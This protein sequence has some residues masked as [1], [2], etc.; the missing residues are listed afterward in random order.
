MRRLALAALS[1]AIACTTSPR[2]PQTNPAAGAQ[3]RADV[4]VERARALRAGG[5]VAG[6]RSR[7]EA[8]LEAEPSS[9]PARIELADLLLA[10]ASEVDRAALL[11]AG[12]SGADGDAR[13]Q[14]LQARLAE[15]RGDDAGAAAAYE[16]ALQLEDD[17]DARLRRAIALDRVG[18]RD[19]ATAEL[20][21]VRNDRPGDTLA[22]SRLADAYEAAGRL[23]AAEAELRAIATAQPDR[24][25]G[26]DRLARFYQ[27]HGR[28]ADARAA[29]ARARRTSGLGD[30][31][32]RPLLPSRR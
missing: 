4:L 11:L 3:P 24:A 29:L 13:A 15:A 7:L 9:A 2:P 19:E 32:L 18:R 25:A 30:R 8:A 17:P 22:R 26:W 14:Q 5:D 6:A 23:D 28:A 21:R 10:D 12:V 31:A 16:R 1:A 27:R 20:E